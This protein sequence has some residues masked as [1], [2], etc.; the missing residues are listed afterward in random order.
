MKLVIDTNILI[1]ALLKKGVTRRLLLSSSHEFH[2]PDYL[3]SEMEHHFDMLKE[4]SGLTMRNLQILVNLLLAEVDIT[5]FK[6]YK[7]HLRNA[8]DLLGGSDVKDVPFLALAMAKNI[9]IWSD[10]QD[11]QQQDRVNVL[12]TNEVIQHTPEV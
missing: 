3:Q 11:F 2:S 12:T 7:D 4:R 9:Q 8:M 6:E 10:D 5:P 1:S